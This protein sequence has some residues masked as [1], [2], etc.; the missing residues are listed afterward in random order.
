MIS[1]FA[2]RTNP[3]TAFKISGKLSI[4]SA[5]SYNAGRTEAPSKYEKILFGRSGISMVP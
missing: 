2:M 1:F 4:K 3:N 5:I